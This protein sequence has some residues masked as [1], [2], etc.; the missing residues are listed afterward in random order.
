MIIR[1]VFDE[2]FLKS[3]GDKVIWLKQTDPDTG[4]PVGE[5]APYF[6][7]VSDSPVLRN[8]DNLCYATESVYFGVWGNAKHIDACKK[9]Y[10]FL[11]EE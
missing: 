6:I 4:E 2:S 9:F 8:T 11:Y 5:E 10:D 3:L 1:E 7:D